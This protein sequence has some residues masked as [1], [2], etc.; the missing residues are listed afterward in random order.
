LAYPDIPPRILKL[1][2]LA[3]SDH[4]HLKEEDLCYHVWEYVKGGTYAKYA[5]NGLIWNLQIDPIDR[6]N[7]RLRHKQTAIAHVARAIETS[8]PQDLK[9]HFTWVPVPPSA[10]RGDP[11]HDSRLAQVLARL[12]PRLPDYRE[13]VLQIQSTNSKEKDISPEERAANYRIDES[14]CEPAPSN[15]VVF[16][17]VIAGGSHFKAMKTVLGN[18]FPGCGVVGV[19]VARTIRP[20]EPTIDID[21]LLANWRPAK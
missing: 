19:F 6:G 4:S 20:D 15:F 18:R 10:V 2:S 5:T 12:S 3:L 21:A 16:D 1:D 17:D 7:F 8:V 13:L 9:D 11:R 14:V